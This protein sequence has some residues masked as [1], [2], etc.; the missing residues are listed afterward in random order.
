MYHVDCDRISGSLLV[1]LPRD[2][3]SQAHDVTDFEL[4]DCQ[5]HNRCLQVYPHSSAENEPVLEVELYLA[6][7]TLVIPEIPETATTI[8]SG[9]CWD[10]E[11][12]YNTKSLVVLRFAHDEL[13]SQWN[14]ISVISSSSF[15]IL[16]SSESSFSTESASVN[17]PST[18]SCLARG[19]FLQALQMFQVRT[20]YANV[21]SDLQV[22]YSCGSIRAYNPYRM[23]GYHYT[24]SP[25]YPHITVRSL[26]N[27]PFLR[28]TLPEHPDH[29]HRKHS[30]KN[31]LVKSLSLSRKRSS[32]H[33]LKS[34][35]S[36]RSQSPSKS[37]LEALSMTAL[38]VPERHSWS[39]ITHKHL[40]TGRLL[41]RLPPFVQGN[42]LLDQVQLAYRSDDVE[43]DRLRSMLVSLQCLGWRRIDVLFGSVMAH[44]QILAKR[45][46]MKKPLNGGLDIVHHVMDTFVL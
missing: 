18:L 42:V 8:T 32:S 27:A 19:Q 34:G 13:P 4:Y 21:F 36:V 45:A 31:I 7:V 6:Q 20:A 2:P 22:P 28:D 30:V 11:I 12:R 29:K 39:G 10:I 23:D 41:D 37:R 9:L 3:T 1:R 38:D 5:I 25:F 17:P 44:E 43:R 33:N 15:G 24:T 16:C 26:W 46:N 40:A 14:W 35:T